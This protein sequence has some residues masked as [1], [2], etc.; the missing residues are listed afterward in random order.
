MIEKT[1]NLGLNKPVGEANFN[2]KHFND[3]AD[4]IDA[5]LIKKADIT[6]VDE[7]IEEKA[8]EVTKTANNTFSNVIKGEESDAV[9]RVDDVSPIEH[10]M[11]VRVRSKNLV[12]FTDRTQEQNGVTF[13]RTGGV[14]TVNG[15]ATESLTA[16]YIETVIEKSG[17][18]SCSGA[19]EGSGPQ[20]YSLFFIHQK[21]DGSKSYY[22]DYGTG[23]TVYVEVGEILTFYIQ[24]QKGVTVEN[25]VFKPQIEYGEK[26][27]PFTPFVDVT[28]AVVTRGGKNIANVPETSVESANAW[29]SKLMSTVLLPS[30]TYTLSMD[31][32]QEGEQTLIGASAKE[33]GNINVSYGEATMGDARGR[34][35]MSFTIPDEKFGADIHWHCNRSANVLNSRCTFSNVQ[36]EKGSTATEFEPYKGGEMSVPSSDGTLENITSISP[37]TTLAVNIN[38]ALIDAEYNKDINKVIESLINAIISLGGNV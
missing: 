1:K 20:T 5:E 28:G 32:V 15:T 26:I 24:I 19:P 16:L 33:R 21:K 25:L 37:C 27:T 13:L 34:L 17:I 14:I 30:G 29:G 3:N 36:I 23:K 31:F 38:G 4:I 9:V 18:Y 22:G 2:I 7:K 6:Y 35:V 8:T 12:K 10:N 11:D